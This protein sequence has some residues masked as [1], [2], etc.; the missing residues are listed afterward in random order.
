[1]GHI[2]APTNFRYFFT[3][4]WKSEWVS[5]LK[6]TNIYFFYEDNIIINLVNWFY[7]T[8]LINHNYIIGNVRILRSFSSILILILFYNADF[9]RNL[10][11][12]FILIRKELSKKKIFKKFKQIKYI[13]KL[14]DVYLY[15]IL[16]KLKIMMI[17][18][19]YFMYLNRNNLNKISLIK[20]LKK[21]TLSIIYVYLNFLNFYFNNT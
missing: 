13:K 4:F 16:K 7:K 14:N 15:N 17:S 12:Y 3:L 10:K 5:I 11:H 6:N 18:L 19:K 2:T 8:Q 20:F 21:K 1:M 9:E